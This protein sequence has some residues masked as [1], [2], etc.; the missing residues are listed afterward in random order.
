MIDGRPPV[1]SIAQ[2]IGD[3]RRGVTDLLHA[4][5]GVFGAEM[6]TKLSSARSSIVWLVAGGLSII[7]ALDLAVAAVFLLM[8]RMGMRPVVAAAT[9]CAVFLCLG[10][11]AFMQGVAR[12]RRVSIKPDRT[13]ARL[14]DDAE[15]LKG[16]FSNA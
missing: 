6:R 3:A 9:L 4:E 10:L 11:V 13:M 14:R 1:I 5:I 15:A 16:N 8:V 2:L 12:L 7:I